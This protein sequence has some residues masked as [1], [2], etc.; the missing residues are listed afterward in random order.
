MMQ[1][2]SSSS[3]AIAAIAPTQ[4]YTWNQYRCAYE[5]HTP[6]NSDAST[7]IP[8]LL[9]HPI[10]VGLSRRFWERF[11][12]QWLQSGQPNPIYNPDLLGC[13]ESDMPHLA[14]TPQD[15]AQQLQHFL[16]TVVQKPVILVVQGALLPVAISLTQLQSQAPDE[17]NWIRGLVLAG[18]PAWA[19]ITNATPAWRHQAAWNLLDSPL[20]SIFYRY[21]RSRGFLRSFSTRELFAKTSDVD[22]EWLDALAQGAANP[23]SRYAVF[24]FLA[25]FWRQDYE[26]ALTKISRPTFV[27]Y[28]QRASSISRTGEA[29]TPDQRLTSYLEHLP[30]SKGVEISGRNVLPYESTMEFVTVTSTFINE[31][32]Q[33]SD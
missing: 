17:A 5:L 19:L 30:H 33:D 29:E 16:Q 12:R 18:P 4:Y 11:C 15:W 23:A 27:I 13:G 1:V 2:E 25:G 3:S 22:R 28:G 20:G 32:D 31:L 26:A 14:Y 24:S 6:A 10:G 9:I 21:A 8:L 7:S